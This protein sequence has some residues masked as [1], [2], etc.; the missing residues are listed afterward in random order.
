MNA[1]HTVLALSLLALSGLSQAGDHRDHGRDGD[2]GHRVGQHQ[3]RESFTEE[4]VRKGADGKVSKR[5]TE[6][7]VTDTGFTRKSSVTNP[8][9]K[10]ATREV[11]VSHDKDKKTFSRSE[12][13]TDFDGKSWSREFKGEGERG[14]KMKHRRDADGRGEKRG[15]GRGE[16]GLNP[17][18]A[19]A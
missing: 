15:E 2:R 19:K 12:K 14:G 1:K 4:T 3:P 5:K 10:T 17:A 6:Q 11:T 9:G 16:A 18:P 7:K 8:E 13:G